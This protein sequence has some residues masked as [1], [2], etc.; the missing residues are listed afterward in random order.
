MPFSECAAAMRVAAN[1]WRAP[2]VAEMHLPTNAR[3]EMRWPRRQ[4]IH[5]CWSI[6]LRE[7]PWLTMAMGRRIAPERQS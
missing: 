2:I 5:D 1:E 3:D 6:L 7:A 4:F